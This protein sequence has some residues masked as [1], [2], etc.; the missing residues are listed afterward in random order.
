MVAKGTD[1]YHFAQHIVE[2]IWKIVVKM[3][4]FRLQLWPGHW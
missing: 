1:R 3:Q 4:L 2:Q